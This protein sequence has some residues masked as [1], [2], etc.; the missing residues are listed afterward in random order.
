M[1]PQSRHDPETEILLV[2]KENFSLTLEV[3]TCPTVNTQ[4]NVDST[5]SEWR[6][7]TSLLVALPD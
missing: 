3:A 7:K 2:A 1:S 5:S 4:K 6:T